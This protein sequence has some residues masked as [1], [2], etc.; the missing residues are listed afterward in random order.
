MAESS[1][2]L[3]R[4]ESTCKSDALAQSA[5]EPTP[6][7]SVQETAS[8]G[9]ERRRTHC[10]APWE[11]SSQV[12]STGDLD[13]EITNESLLNCMVLKVAWKG[14]GSTM[15]VCEPGVLRKADNVPFK[16]FNI[17]GQLLRME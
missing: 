13:L 7:I 9:C 12:G 1:R 14:S 15:V 16:S 2:Q 6:S 4:T 5:L 3:G 17:L 10:V 8:G 11:L